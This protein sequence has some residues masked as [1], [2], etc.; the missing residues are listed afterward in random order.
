MGLSQHRVSS[1]PDKK[2]SHTQMSTPAQRPPPQLIVRSLSAK[3][4]RAMVTFGPFR[5]V[6]ALGRSGVRA[7]KREG[8]GAT[9]RG[10]FA[11]RQVFINPVAWGRGPC[12]LSVRQLRRHDGWCDHSADR[13]Y[14]RPVRH[15]YPA[16]AEHLWRADG[17]YDAV[18]V[19]GYND[20]PRVRGRGSAIFIHIARPGYLPTEGCVA[21]SARDMR[22]LLPHLR[23]TTQLITAV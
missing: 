19:V 10:R 6:C 15:P 16:S 12:G 13:N 21:L 11:L 22:R 23:R 17:L 20:S 9:P 3:A 18:I 8:D 7:L 2:F 14:N 1:S 4:T 5:M